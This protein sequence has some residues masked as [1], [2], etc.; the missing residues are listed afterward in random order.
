VDT[1]AADEWQ[2]CVH[3]VVT[4]SGRRLCQSCGCFLCGAV[5]SSD[6]NDEL[7]RCT[8]CHAIVAHRLC[9]ASRLAVPTPLDRP[10][11]SC[12]VCAPVG[13]DDEQ[14]APPE[15][16]AELTALLALAPAFNVARVMARCDPRQ[17]VNL[18]NLSVGAAL[19]HAVGAASTVPP[20]TAAIAD[21]LG[22]AGLDYDADEETLRLRT[23]TSGDDLGDD[24]AVLAFIKQMFANHRE[25]AASRK[26]RVSRR[27]A[28]K[29]RRRAK[30]GAESG[31]G[32]STDEEAAPASPK[33]P[34]P[35]TPEDDFASR[36]RARIEANQAKLNL[37]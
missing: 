8:G 3:C 35:M 1:P 15:P 31:D 13:A 20:T 36:R 23:A 12:P 9:V 10:A 14:E 4:A 25:K 2:M 24:A 21:C 29:K 32:S 33:T 5:A 27:S 28:S 22:H 11:T 37:L 16:T 34:P 26:P 17:P 19:Q 30:T 18:V 6:R 7:M